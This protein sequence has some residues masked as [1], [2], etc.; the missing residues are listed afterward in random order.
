MSNG[1]IVALFVMLILGLNT[2]FVCALELDYVTSRDTDE[3]TY[4]AYLLAADKVGVLFPEIGC[5]P[6]PAQPFPL[7]LRLLQAGQ[8]QPREAYASLLAYPVHALCLGL[9]D[10]YFAMKLYPIAYYAVVYLCWAGA[11]ARCFPRPV[12]LLASCWFLFCPF[13]L[14]F[15]YLYQMGSQDVSLL[16]TSLMVLA[17]SR[18][19]HRHPLPALATAALIGGVGLAMCSK[20]LVDLLALAGLMVLFATR[21]VLPWRQL[22]LLLLA[23]IAGYLP[24]PLGFIAIGLPPHA[25]FVD[26]ENSNFVGYAATPLRF[27]HN[28][29]ALPEEL[30]KL[31]VYQNDLAPDTLSAWDWLPLLLLAAS[32]AGLLCHLARCRAQWHRPRTAVRLFLLA[33]LAVFS[34]T[35]LAGPVRVYYIHVIATY[36]SYR[37]FASAYP[38]FFVLLGWGTA[39]ALA[40]LRGS[41]R[42]AFAL[43][44]LSLLFWHPVTATLHR[45]ASPP[46]PFTMFDM[47]PVQF[48][49]LG[50]LLARTT[51]GVPPPAV[52]Q[53][54]LALAER[55]DDIALMSREYFRVWF[56]RQ[57]LTDTGL[58]AVLPEL[59]HHEVRRGFWGALG[60]HSIEQEQQPRFGGGHERD[61][62]FNVFHPGLLLQKADPGARAEYWRGRGQADISLGPVP[63]HGAVVAA[64]AAALP[65]PERT[66]YLEG[67]GETFFQ[68]NYILSVIYPHHE[69]SFDIAGRLAIIDSSFP[70]EIRQPVRRGALRAAR[71]LLLSPAAAIGGGA[72]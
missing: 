13:N 62:V 63:H 72:E 61:K 15:T 46:A 33:H 38:V 36:T 70:P 29:R 48:S 16:F 69:F 23:V 56:C 6:R 20:N 2:A 66:W 3:H 43:L 42:P 25:Q 5:L 45:L 51:P 55:Q 7:H 47:R 59:R 44:L 35:Y 14:R 53:R 32:L 24:L 11:I 10:S 67:E 54:L 1:K 39:A 65:E 4:L 30:R 31:F 34:F 52:E 22:P 57:P 71:R 50:W 40:R 21:G 17:L 64:A 12:L 49:P 41:S 18:L 37:Y 9:A 28:N 27:L 58:A 26:F 68:S 19:R 60:A 8:F